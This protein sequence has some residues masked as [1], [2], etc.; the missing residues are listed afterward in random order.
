MVVVE[1]GTTCGVHVGWCRVMMSSVMHNNK[2]HHLLL[3]PP[4]RGAHTPR[5]RRVLPQR[6]LLMLTAA[7]VA[8]HW[9]RRGG[10]PR[11]SRT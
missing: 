1:G 11:G 3:S 5:L 6:L 7:D 2:L 4:P 10:P 9:L 8:V